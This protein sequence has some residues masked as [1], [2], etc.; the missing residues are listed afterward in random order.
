MLTKICDKFRFWLKSNT[1]TG[2]LYTYMVNIWPLLIFI[3]EK[4]FSMQYEVK[5]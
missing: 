2:T 4:L 1:I 5:L 3:I